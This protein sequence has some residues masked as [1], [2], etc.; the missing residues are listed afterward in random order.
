MIWVP[1]GR[2]ADVD[3][4]APVD[5]TA[6][7]EPATEGETRRAGFVLGTVFDVSQTEETRPHGPR[8]DEAECGGAFDGFA[9]TSDADPGL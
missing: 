8:F 1:T 3:E 2:T 6:A 7:G 5:A 9:V 4:P